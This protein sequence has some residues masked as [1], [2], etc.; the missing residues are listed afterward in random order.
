[1][2]ALDIL[3]GFVMQDGQRWGEAATPWQKEDAQ[4]ILEPGE[5]PRRHWAGRPRG[6]SKTQDTAGMLLAEL[7][8]GQI[9]P[10]TPA[11]AAAAGA[12]QAALVIQS[13]RAFVVQNSLQRLVDVQSMR[14]VHRPTSAMVEVLAA[15]E[16][17]AFG[18]RPSR[19][20]T[21][22]VCQWSNTRSSQE[23]F[24]AAWTALP[25]VNG[26]VGVI[27]TTA[28]SPSHWSR[29]IFD[30]ALREKHLW[31]VSMVHEPAPWI[32][33]RLIAAEKRR[34]TDS[35]FLRLWCNE[36]ANADDA[37]VSQDDLQAAA[38]LDGPVAPVPGTHYVSALDIG[39]VNDRTVLIVA[40]KSGVGE[41]ERV[42]VDRVFRWFGTKRN[43]VSL[44]EV[45]A[46]IVE[47]ATNY[48]G[49]LVADPYQA[50]QL[51]ERVGKRGVKGSKFDFTT[52]SVGRVASSLLRLLRSR[53]LSLP[54]DPVLLEELANVRLVENSAGVPR[55]DHVS[56]AHD[57]Q[58]VALALCCHRLTDGAPPKRRG[59]RLKF[60]GRSEPLEGEIVGRV[61][62]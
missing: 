20:L 3:H 41:E 21:D 48:S 5:G 13:I 57:D 42:V 11:Y 47:V 44:D 19:L 56:G 53:R 40:H 1:M 34:L 16:S 12:K 51:L 46:V 4:A 26:S 25:K 6:S 23:F 52:Q 10:S 32:D 62:W 39:L 30:Q 29:A 2:S 22:E 49:E 7:L 58:A 17:T 59:A 55:L 45:E 61:S 27:I 15:D 28:G 8:A 35:A 38:V 18:L 31:R 43:P 54:N 14:A 24:E 36:W 9:S 37:L 60:Y 33:Q 50:A